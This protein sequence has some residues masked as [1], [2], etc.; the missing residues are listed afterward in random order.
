M[1]LTAIAVGAP[2]FGAAV[3]ALGRQVRAVGLTA[4]LAAVAASGLLLNTASRSDSLMPALMLLYA[5][6]TA[7]AMLLLPRRD[8]TAGT[9]SGILFLLGST[10]LTYS[11]DHLYLLFLGWILSAAPFLTSR[12]FGASSWRPRAAL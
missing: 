9:T 8:C 4:S 10:L 2:C 5:C 1:V 11:S 12:W 6:L 3:A 7:A